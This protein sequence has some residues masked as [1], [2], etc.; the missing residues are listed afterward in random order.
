MTKAI[1]SATFSFFVMNEI[2]VNLTK[3]LE[4][5]WFYL[6]YFISLIDIIVRQLRLTRL[7][8]ITWRRQTNLQ[9]A[10]NKVVVEEKSKFDWW[11]SFAYWNLKLIQFRL[12]FQDIWEF[13][14]NFYNLVVEENKCSEFDTAEH[15]LSASSYKSIP[16][17]MIKWNTWTDVYHVVSRWSSKI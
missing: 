9:T 10:L 5:S 17:T 7:F 2:A 4:R 16:F 6:K 13:H 15:T 1:I 12:L 8:T 11:F 3:Q 14:H